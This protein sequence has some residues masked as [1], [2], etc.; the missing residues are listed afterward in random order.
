MV[1]TVPHILI[2]DD[3]RAILALIGAR[4]RQRDYHVEMVRD[5]R[6]ALEALRQQH[7]D[8]LLLDLMMPEVTGY[9]VL[10]RIRQDSAFN[11]MPI[12]VMSAIS[13]MSSVVK[14]IELGAEDYLFKP[15][16]KSLFWARVNTLI[17]KKKL[18][19]HEKA[20]LQ[21]LAL[22][23]QIDR[24]LN[25]TLDAR[26]AA[27]IALHEACRY[28]NAVCGAIGR[29]GADAQL[30][31]LFETAD[32]DRCRRVLANLPLHTEAAE[33]RQLFLEPAVRLDPAAPFRTFVPL[34]QQA[35]AIGCMIL[36]HEEP[37]VEQQLHFLDL[38]AR[39]AAV[40][41]GNALLHERAQAENEAKTDFLAFVAHELKSPLT[42]LKAYSDLVS[43]SNTKRLLEKKDQ[44]L[45]IL[46]RTVDRMN[47]L[48]SE[49]NDIAAIESGRFSILPR[50]LDLLVLV[51]DALM[52][53]EAVAAEKQLTINLDFAPD[54]PSVRGDRQRVQQVIDNLLSNAIKY[55]PSRGWIRVTGELVTGEGHPF[56]RIAV[57]DSGMGIAEE[58]QKG[59]FRQFFR[60]ETA[61]E[62][63]IE[64]VGLGLHIVKTLVELQGGRIWFDSALGVGT[65]FY[66]T[67][68]LDTTDRPE[69]N[70]QA[71]V[72]A[73]AQA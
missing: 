35:D 15:F 24:E 60:T 27:Q 9:E 51:E 58:D 67:L 22:L 72:A 40:A 55:T 26:Q 32:A 53:F 31:S 11:D 33:K 66:F 38:L 43:N 37:L 42:V 44:Y 21:E 64:G 70:E 45:D 1:E 71:T 56:A 28:T 4:L 68:P 25:A 23:Q 59:I 62:H 73:V 10:E 30:W 47:R 69:I 54:M 12:V 57:A 17:D 6:A 63:G 13:D 16:H 52:Q 2:A 50:P 14:C 3:D 34:Q 8:L 18:R 29:V 65:T 41:L 20:H 48:V 7:F 49:L 36:D 46:E 39:H 19:D 5:G 61:V